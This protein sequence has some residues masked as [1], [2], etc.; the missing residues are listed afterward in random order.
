MLV[1]SSLQCGGA[2]RVLADMANY[3]AR[4]GVGVTYATWAGPEVA[5]F[6][7]L[8]PAVRRVW[9][10]LPQSGGSLRRDCFRAT[11]GALSSTSGRP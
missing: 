7:R 3:W 1:T 9:L 11:T 8:D 5:D 6:Y 4:S 2:E 10:D